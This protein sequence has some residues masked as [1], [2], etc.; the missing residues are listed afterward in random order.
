[1]QKRTINTT[2]VI[3]K[4]FTMPII[5]FTALLL[6]SC[7]PQNQLDRAATVAEPYGPP[8]SAAPFDPTAREPVAEWTFGGD[9]VRWSAIDARGRLGAV[10][11]RD[12]PLVMILDLEQLTEP[13]AIEIPT[14]SGGY[15]HMSVAFEPSGTRL[16][17]GLA[18][19]KVWIVD[20]GDGE[21]TRVLRY[22]KGNMR[23]PVMN[24]QFDEAGGR[25]LGFTSGDV[26]VWSLASGEPEFLWPQSGRVMAVGV[27]PD[28]R[29]A[30][31]A[32]SDALRVM[33]LGSGEEV[34]S[35][36]VEF[37]WVAIHPG[38]ERAAAWDFDNRVVI[39]KISDCS[40]IGS[41]PTDHDFVTGMAWAA[42]GEHL[43]LAS[44][45]GPLYVYEAASG[46][47]VDQ[48]PAQNEP[49]LVVSAH[50]SGRVL[51]T[52]SGERAKAI[53]WEGSSIR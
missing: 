33:D 39:L 19:G 34:C 48:W 7:A 28:G 27:T 40:E 9:A 41:W 13:R 20:S 24:V 14:S 4:R 43:I 50:G 25:I 10:T 31:V 6:S 18:N 15:M 1:M 5:L 38:G 36:P 35:L 16:A 49:S 37:A 12:K 23:T 51:S 47:L 44:S 8:W 2:D 45:R 42:D 3:V 11:M 46:E 53:L 26:V 22:S 30:T 32:G 29:Y 52:G 17:I 21:T